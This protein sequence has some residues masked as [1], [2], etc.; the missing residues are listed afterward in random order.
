MYYPEILAAAS[1]VI[2][3]AAPR[4]RTFG[5]PFGRARRRLRPGRRPLRAGQALPT[6]EQAL[7]E[8]GSFAAH[9]DALPAD[10]M[11][12][13]MVEA[14]RLRDAVAGARRACGAG[15]AAARRRDHRQRPRAGR[16]GVPALLRRRR[17]G[18]ERLR[19]GPGG[20]GRRGG[21]RSTV[22]RDGRAERPDPC[23]VFRCA[24]PLR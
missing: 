24:I 6:A 8:A 18:T 10:M 23:A 19:A 2:M 12:P 14:Q 4:A 9:C 7:R 1:P 21:R 15:R 3:G 20:G 22:A 11:L 5:G 17:A 16:L 13:G